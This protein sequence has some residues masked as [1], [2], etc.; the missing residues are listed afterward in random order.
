MKEQVFMAEKKCAICKE[1]AEKCICCP[2]CGHVCS[3]DYGEIYCPVC[4]PENNKD[5]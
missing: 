4:F 2:E 1:P 3:L 5:K